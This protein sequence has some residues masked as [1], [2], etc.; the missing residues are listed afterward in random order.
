MSA[1]TLDKQITSYLGLLNVS[2]K[3]AVL[4]VVKNFA[5]AYP[6]TDIW[7]DEESFIAEMDR[8]VHEFETGKVKVVTLEE[9]E[10]QA[11]EAFRKKKSQK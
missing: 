10:A 6:V 5:D 1:A 7:K 2:Q 9:M 11:R 3:K 8:R 4:S